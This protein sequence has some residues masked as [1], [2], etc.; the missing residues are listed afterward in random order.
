MGERNNV[1]TTNTFYQAILTLR[2]ALEEVGL[3]RDTV[4]TI[5]R[6]GLRL[7][8]NTQVEVI[9]HTQSD[10][11]LPPV[12]EE[13]TTPATIVPSPKQTTPVPR[14]GILFTLNVLIATTG[15]LAGVVSETP[16][17]AIYRLHLYFHANSLKSKLQNLLFTE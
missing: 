13:N 1:T 17:D 7:T 16:G 3:P 14:W 10:V 2:K 5:S 8:E 6:R 12:I 15:Y 4:K 11:S 9:T